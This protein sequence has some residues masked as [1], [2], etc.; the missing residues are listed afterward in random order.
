MK[1]QPRSHQSQLAPGTN[2]CKGDPNNVLPSNILQ[3]MGWEGSLSPGGAPRQRVLYASSMKQVALLSAQ[4]P[5]V[6]VPK[7][8]L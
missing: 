5:M 8:S 1:P 7:I 6:M 3:E 2:W 4:V